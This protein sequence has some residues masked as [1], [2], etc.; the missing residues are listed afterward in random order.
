MVHQLICCFSIA[1][2]L[3]GLELD[4]RV[5]AETFKVTFHFILLI[6]Y[7]VCDTKRPVGPAIGMVCQFLMMPCLA[8][9][10]GWLFLQTRYERLGLLLLG[11]SPGGANSNFWVSGG[12]R[13]QCLTY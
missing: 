4:L 13:G 6:L 8:Y 12:D 5:V 11:T 1:L 10:L 9:L 3:M 7:Y 2:I